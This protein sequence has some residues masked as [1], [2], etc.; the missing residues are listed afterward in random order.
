LVR[1]LVGVVVLGTL[2]AVIVGGAALAW[3][4]GRALPETTGSVRLPGLDFGATVRRDIHGIAQITASTTHDLFMTQGFVHA[5]ERMWQMDVWRHIGSGRLSELFGHG[6][7][8]TD[9][10][11][12]TLGW[13]Q[14]AE[15]DLAAMPSD[16]RAILDAYS[17]GVN[18]WLD[19]HRDRLGLAYVVTG[20]TPESWTALDTLVFGKLQAWNLG[21][22][23]DAE[24]F[25]YLADQRLGDPA[26]TD[27]LFPTREFGPVIVPESGGAEPEAMA[28]TTSGVP[29]APAWPR[30]TAAG[31][32]PLTALQA[33]GWRAVGASAHRS[34]AVA[35]LDAGGDALASD[36]A[37][38]SNDWV[39]APSLSA[40]GGALL[41]ND[42]HLGIS[43]PSV[44]YVNG[45]HCVRVDDACPWDVVGVTFPGV[46]GVVLGHNARIA[47][48]VTNTNPDVEDLVI[49]TV[50]AADPAHYIGPDGTSLPFVTRTE[51]I[52]VA[53]G[54]PVELTVRSTVH[55]PILNDVDA[56]LADA[57]LMALRWTAIDPAVGPDGTLE[58]FLRVDTA[59]DFDAFRSALSTFVAPAQNFV[60]AD[61]DGHIG[62]QLPGSIPIRSDP[63]DR[64]LRPVNGSDGSGEWTGRIGFADLPSAY[65]PV[66][67]WL[68]SANNAVVDP[69]DPRFIGADFDPGYRA[70]RIIDQI[71]DRAQDGLT[72]PEMSAIQNDTAPLRA[73]DIVLMLSDAHTATPDG[74]LIAARIADWDGACLVD[75]RGCAAYMAW[76]YRVTRDIFD[77][78]LADLARDYVG[79][80]P[81]WVALSNLLQDP[82]ASWWDDVSTPDVKETAPGIVG[83][84]MDEAGAEL[85]AAIGDPGEWTWGRLHTA[86]FRE[87]TIGTASGIGPLE[88]YFNA[89][90]VVVG[91]AAGAIDNTYYR[92]DRAY[93]DPGDPEAPIVGIAGIFS[94]TNLPSY[95]L[96]IDLKDLDG[97]RIVITTGQSG[98]PFDHHYSDQI[99]PWRTGGTLPLPFTPEAVAAATVATLTLEP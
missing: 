76:E 98:N 63:D 1:K 91:G 55:G 24:L 46:P 85:R 50:D 94:V 33:D 60:Y 26:L 32:P 88:W 10:F 17:A 43:M 39:V 9:R 57:P 44:W 90:P 89:G 48:G 66:E 5:Q 22:N 77:D 18:A 2:I 3:I 86:T 4:T 12:R 92:F 31:V 29:P 30:S 93:A 25:R 83:R 19:G 78:D 54:D 38:G 28:G 73:R 53:G 36:H 72:V 27:Q 35:G 95:R 61:V 42:P 56:R 80:A 51:H 41:A 81:S 7:L 70:E 6:S 69:G 87:A 97:A 67:G 52:S 34:L 13:R 96:A 20:S 16:V 14:A 37:I 71:N 40:T 47:W 62:Y 84:A 64:G 15:R 58:A 68:V 49:E 99:E 8:D 11:I 74:A 75:S 65:D 82:A 59:R 79:S 21:G 45:L 23:M